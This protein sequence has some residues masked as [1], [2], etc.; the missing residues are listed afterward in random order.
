MCRPPQRNPPRHGDCLSSREPIHARKTEA[1]HVDEEEGRCTGA[2]HE[3]FFRWPLFRTR[4]MFE[5][6]TYFPEIDEFEK[7]NRIVTKMDLPGLK[8]ED[9]KVEVVDGQLVIS[10]ERKNEIEEKRENF[11][12]CERA[13]GSFYRTVS[14]RSASRCRPRRWRNRRRSRSASRRNPRRPPRNEVDLLSCRLASPPA[15]RPSFFPAA[16]SAQCRGRDGE[17][18]EFSLG[19]GNRRIGRF[20]ATTEAAS[21]TGTP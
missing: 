12:R 18:R 14:W 6:A 16:G 20:E 2:V 3:P 4:P 17:L 9:V 1:R 5:S 7:D 11:Y 15:A 13:Y 19:A 21:E 8:K 10:G